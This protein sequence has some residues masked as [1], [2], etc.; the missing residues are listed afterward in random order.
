MQHARSEWKLRVLIVSYSGPL[1]PSVASVT[2]LLLIS[3]ELA[4]MLSSVSCKILFN[5]LSA[6]DFQLSLTITQYFRCVI[7]RYY[8]FLFFL[9]L[10]SLRVCVFHPHTPEKNVSGNNTYYL[11]YTLIFFI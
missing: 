3:S 1:I 4:W 11:S 5:Y 6:C 7:S 10:L 2:C 8:F 9:F